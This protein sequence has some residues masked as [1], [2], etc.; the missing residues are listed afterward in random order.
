MLVHH[1][2]CATMCPMGGRLLSGKGGLFDT[3][4]LVCHC[5]LI[6]GPNGLILVDTGFGRQ[7]IEEADKRLGKA[8]LKL[9]RPRLD[10]SETAVRQVMRLGFK[11]EDVRDILLTHLDPD[12]AGGISDF[13]HARIHVY[14]PEHRVACHPEDFKDRRR[15]RKVQWSHGPHWQ[16]H[17]LDGEQWEGFDSVRALDESDPEVLLIPLEGHTRGHCGVAVHTDDGWLLH[18][19][20][21]FFHHRQMDPVRPSIPGGLKWFQRA[22]DTDR[23]QRETNQERLRILSAASSHRIKVFCAHDPT[24]YEECCGS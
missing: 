2:N 3:A 5:L 13:P 22:V 11:P 19:G 23:K 10:K 12:H 21:A 14:E 6:E 20:D 24:Q 1:I 16:I 7:D 9:A 18:A 15:Y 17:Q 4:H 8:F